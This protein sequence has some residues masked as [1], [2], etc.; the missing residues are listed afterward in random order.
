[1][2]P[3]LV[4]SMEP[5]YAFQG[6]KITRR[7]VPFLYLQTIFSRNYPVTVPFTISGMSNT[8]C[9]DTYCFIKKN[10]LLKRFGA[11]CVWKSTLTKA[12]WTGVIDMTP[13]Q[14]SGTTQGDPF[15]TTI[16]FFIKFDS[17]K[18]RVPFRETAGFTTSKSNR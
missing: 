4:V 5:L 16:H 2:C 18:K 13:T 12:F 15:K 9:C 1:M 14:T 17:P 11:R 6:T 10:T 8:S 7:C 3:F